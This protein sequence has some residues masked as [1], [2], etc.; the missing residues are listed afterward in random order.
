M[1]G[2]RNTGD[3]MTN[4]VSRAIWFVCDAP[5]DIDACVYA[6]DAVLALRADPPLCVKHGALLVSW[7]RHDGMS[8]EAV[9][10]DTKWR[11][12]WCQHRPVKGEK[13]ASNISP[14]PCNHR[15]DGRGCCIDC[16]TFLPAAEGKHWAAGQFEIGA[17]LRDR[18]NRTRQRRP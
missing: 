9:L 10:R 17:M 11:E 12:L 18:R 8:R 2:Q 13:I 5:H 3:A 6:P 16:G 7:R 14:E 4:L 1:G 15:D